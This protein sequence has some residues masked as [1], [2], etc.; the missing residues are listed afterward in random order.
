MYR[1]AENFA[2][3]VAKTLSGTLAS[4][5]STAL[6]LSFVLLVNPMSVNAESYQS[7]QHVEPAYEGWRPNPDGSFSF[8]FGYMNEN[9][10]EEPN[11]AVGENNFFPQV[12]PIVPNLLIF[13]LAETASH[14]KSWCRQIGVSVN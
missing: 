1:A 11:A 8:M 9:W 4:T 14:L 2:K 13:Y 5:L 7:G 3:T 12:K 6:A 10:S